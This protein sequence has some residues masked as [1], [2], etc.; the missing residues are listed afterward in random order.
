MTKYAF[1]KLVGDLAEALRPEEDDDWA[2]AMEIL[3]KAFKA[4]E[5]RVIKAL[6]EEAVCLCG[7]DRC[8]MP[9]DKL[10]CLKKEIR[11]E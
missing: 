2:R 11:G 3:D 6:E 1:I 4:E 9:C 10:D 5:E 7:S 8:D